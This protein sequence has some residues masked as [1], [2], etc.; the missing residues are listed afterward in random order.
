MDPIYTPSTS[1]TCDSE[2]SDIAVIGLA[3]RFPGGASNAEK[4]WELLYNKKCEFED[5]HES[6]PYSDEEMRVY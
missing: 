6:C 3:C 5:L 2:S 1:V 4:F